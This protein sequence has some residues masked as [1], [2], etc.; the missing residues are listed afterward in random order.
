MNYKKIV[1]SCF[2]FVITVCFLTN[3]INSEIAIDNSAPKFKNNNNGELTFYS[4]SSSLKLNKTS[5]ST[6]SSKPADLSE[7]SKKLNSNSE[8]KIISKKEKFD[9][10]DFS[11]LNLDIFSFLNVNVEEPHVDYDL[12]DELSNDLLFPPEEVI[13][14]EEYTELLRLAASNRDP[15]INSNSNTTVP[16]L[17][18]T[19]PTTGEIHIPVLLVDFADQPH[20]LESTVY[21]DMYNS[22]NYLDDS[23]ISVKDYYLHES[24]GSLNFV[25]DIY[26]WQTLSN[27]TYEYYR[28]T[29]S[30]QW[31]MMLDTI[32]LFD[33][34]VDFSQYDNDGDGRLDGIV[35]IPAGN[36]SSTYGI[37]SHVRI[38]KE[39]DS[40]PVDGKYLGNTALIPEISSGSACYPEDCRT[41]VNT[42]THE[43][44]H[45]LGLPD[46]YEINPT[47]GAQE[48]LGI[49][50]LSMMSW[51][52][53]NSQKPINLDPWSRFYLGWL[54][55][56]FIGTYGPSMQE[57]EDL[58][59]DTIQTLRSVNDY[60]DLV[61]VSS[62]HLND[63]EFFLVENRFVDV[64]DPNNLD[65]GNDM[66]VDPDDEFG[67]LGL[68]IYHIDEQY[69]ED[70]FLTNS[71]A[72]DPDGDYYDDSGGHPGIVF[73]QNVL[74]N[75]GPWWFGPG[76]F[77]INHV[78]YDPEIGTLPF[79]YFNK[80]EYLVPNANIFEDTT[81][82]SYNGVQ[83]T[84][85][86]IES[87]SPGGFSIDAE[88]DWQ[89]CYGDTSCAI[90]N[91]EDY[92]ASNLN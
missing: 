39:Y 71:I 85:I 78:S 23:G 79:M 46:L 88:I 56:T 10:I 73:E 90:Q 86:A 92:C 32:N 76:D 30:T 37:R 31:E 67:H 45:I 35:I 55:G 4:N 33:S 21:E 81:S 91:V 51:T 64:D 54:E 22:D 8:K 84:R 36:N 16:N 28:N 9:T 43:M 68:A 83:N 82:D 38:L 70:N 6:Y 15:P 12:V 50:A 14:K 65:V 75:N 19:C 47:T 44:G 17:T 62:N 58:C 63:R 29:S 49:N 3:F 74:I 89:A 5:I 34:N 59:N 61:V 52:S 69:I 20:T 1:F 41:V 13:S 27:N 48:G 72:H 77:Y 60:P 25:F 26:D 18:G 2:V 80:N 24:Y 11:E 87:L 57:N 40:N 53:T 42:V 66:V 7:A